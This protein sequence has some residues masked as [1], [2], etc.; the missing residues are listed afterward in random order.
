MV[1]PDRTWWTVPAR[2]VIAAGVIATI[3]IQGVHSNT[4]EAAWMAAPV[5]ALAGY[6]GSIWPG[7][8]E[9]ATQDTLQ[10]ARVVAFA[11]LAAAYLAPMFGLTT[12]AEAF[13]ASGGI[14]G[15][16]AGLTFYARRAPR[17]ATLDPSR[18]ASPRSVT[19]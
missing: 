11:C 12:F 8:A 14:V 10:R 17:G 19:A 18:P 3:A 2:A 1:R 4:A 6:L 9:G 13:A 16:A 7:S 5:Y 15:L